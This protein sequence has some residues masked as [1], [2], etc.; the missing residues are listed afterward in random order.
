[1]DKGKFTTV[2][3]MLV[4][5]GSAL[6]SGCAVN[7]E[8]IE[9]Q[10]PYEQVNRK[11]FAFNMSIDKH[12]Y[13]PVAKAYDNTLPAPVKKGVNNFFSNVGEISNVAQDLLQ[14]NVRSA[15]CDTCR[16]AINST[17]GIG[18]LFDFA[19][20]FGIP[21]NNQDFGLTLARWGSK[22]TPYIVLPFIGPSTLRDAVGMSI[23]YTMINVWDYV[24]PPEL[25]YGSLTLKYIDIRANLLAGDKIIDQAFDPYILVRNA[26]LQRRAYLIDNKK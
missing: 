19:S 4:V 9:P 25:R 8:L 13:R 16:F 26:Y 1:M 6:L 15:I 7:K 18:G 11:I 23:D 17:I 14:V 21:K 22:N 10:D 12:V 20:K 2:I 5:L 3:V 24:E